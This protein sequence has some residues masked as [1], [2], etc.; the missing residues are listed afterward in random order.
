MRAERKVA[1]IPRPPRI[2]SRD[3]HSISR[4]YISPN[5]LKVLY[6]LNNAGFKACLVGGGVR[7]LLL[8]REQDAH[9]HRVAV[10]D[11]AMFEM[12]RGRG[13]V[14]RECGVVA[15]PSLAIARGAAGPEDAFGLL[16]VGA[17]QR[18]RLERGNRNR[19]DVA[20]RV[21]RA[22]GFT[23]PQAKPPETLIVLELIGK[24]CQC[25]IVKLGFAGLGA[26]HETND[27]VYD[28]LFGHASTP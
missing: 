11:K 23:G 10:M 20:P 4:K 2:Y 18:E 27:P 26:R 1:S 14:D 24:Q 19:W 9:A 7:D 21:Y 25:Q 15:L 17:A 13:V 22:R 8:G 12:A 6:R 3:E 5:A 28:F 16:R